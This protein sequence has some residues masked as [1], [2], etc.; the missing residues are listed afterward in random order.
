[1][2]LVCFLGT[3]IN[4]KKPG[5]NRLLITI[6]LAKLCSLK[7]DPKFFNFVKDS[8]R[9]SSGYFSGFSRIFWKSSIFSIFS[10]IGTISGGFR[11]VKSCPGA[12]ENFSEI[13]NWKNSHFHSFF[14]YKT[15]EQNFE[16]FNLRVWSTYPSVTCFLAYILE[17]NFICSQS[18][19]KRRKNI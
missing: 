6:K 9:N 12:I 5:K 15:M 2:E 8:F 7:V 18:K 13:S 19:Y 1:M 17:N 14:I 16:I 11:W 10:E 3:Y 4:S